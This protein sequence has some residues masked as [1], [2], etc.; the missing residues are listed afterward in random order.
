MSIYIY[1]YIY[2]Y[3]DIYK[4]Y[5][6]IHIYIYMYIYRE[7]HIDMIKHE[8]NKKICQTSFELIVVLTSV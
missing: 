7:R 2:R 6:Y 8:K 1:I 4:Q 5:I 3:I